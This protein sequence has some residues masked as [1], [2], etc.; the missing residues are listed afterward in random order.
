M[1]GGPHNDAVMMVFCDGAV[2]PISY[3]VS[4]AIFRALGSRN[5]GDLV[6]DY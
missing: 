1:F 6:D 2:R 3:Q 4:P 5:L